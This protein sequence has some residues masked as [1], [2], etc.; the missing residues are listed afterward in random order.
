MQV[1]IS[2]ERNV[3][4][5]ANNEAGRPV[6]TARTL[7]VASLCIRFLR[8]LPE[9]QRKS[10]HHLNLYKGRMSAALSP[11]HVVGLLPLWKEN[12]KLRNERWTDFWWTVIPGAPK[13]TDLRHWDPNMV[14]A[15]FASVLKSTEEMDLYASRWVISEAI[16]VWIEGTKEV[17]AST[18]KG[19]LKLVF[20]TEDPFEHIRETECLFRTLLQD[21]AWRTALKTCQK[22]GMIAELNPSRHLSSTPLRL[23]RF[24]G[25][26]PRPC[27]FS[28]SF[29]S[30]IAGSLDEHL[31]FDFT[32]LT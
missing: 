6:P 25:Q 1:L 19:A 22:L 8:S 23:E 16:T 10:I 7:F 24:A 30:D 5:V 9:R 17:L 26:A 27:H 21:A 14:K 13:Y 3:G 31:F 15:L 28:A 32:I 2:L 29:P 4:I 12:S 20:Y 18:P 11:S